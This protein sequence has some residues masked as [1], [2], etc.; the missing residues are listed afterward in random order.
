MSLTA[1]MRYQ[2]RKP[3]SPLAFA[4]ICS[5]LFSIWSILHL[6]LVNNDAIIYLRTAEVYT[7]GGFSAALQTY[8]WPFYSIFIA[9][10]NKISFLSYQ[11]SAYLLNSVLFIVICYA[12]IKLIQ[13]MGA[14][15]RVQWWSTILILAYPQLNNYRNFIIRDIGYWAFYLLA[16]VALASY[17][18]QRKNIYLFL[19]TFFI[20]MATLF[21]VEGIFFFL[22]APIAFLFIQGNIKL[23]RVVDLLKF[24]AI[25]ILGLFAVMGVMLTD[26]SFMHYAGRLATIILEF[27]Q[28][29]NAIVSALIM[30]KDLMAT[31]ILNVFSAGSAWSFLIAGLIAYYLIKIISATNILLLLTS[32]FSM[33]NKCLPQNKMMSVLV[34]FIVINF[35][36]TLIFLLQQF[37]MVSRY[38]VPLSLLLILPAPFA[39]EHLWQ[40]KVLLIKNTLRLQRVGLVVLMLYLLCSGLLHFGYSKQYIYDAAIWVEQNLPKDKRIYSN[41]RQILYYAHV[42]SVNWQEFEQNGAD[43]FSLINPSTLK[44]FDYLVLRVAHKNMAKLSSRM[45]GINV[46]PIKIFANNRDDEVIIFKVQK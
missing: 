1:L 2:S 18:K 12:F 29:I 13:L 16:I 27:G 25:P 8:G 23:Q 17:S 43:D 28:L 26:N 5:I 40:Q 19:W 9:W 24:E 34:V 3:I 31:S 30:K 10:I 32:A 37:F 14:N 39:F 42:K 4:A 36:V 35:L 15:T 22:L 11:Q 45:Q 7:Q 6:D 33:R 44:N 21:R 20:I 46:V 41:N 38:L